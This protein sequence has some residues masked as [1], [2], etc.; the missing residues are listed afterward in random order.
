LDPSPKWHPHLSGSWQGIGVRKNEKENFIV[1]AAVTGPGN[2]FPLEFIASGKRTRI[3]KTQIGQVDGHWRIP[4]QNGWQTAET[5][6]N[7]LLNL[8]CKI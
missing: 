8:P 7:Y 3:E 4:S 5:F 6:Q 1:I 2:K